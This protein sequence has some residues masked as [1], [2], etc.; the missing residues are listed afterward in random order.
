MN[1]SEWVV[2]ICMPDTVM[3]GHVRQIVQRYIDANLKVIATHT[4][5][6]DM[7][8]AARLYADQKGQDCYE[9]LLC[10]IT[11]GHCTLV[12]IREEDAVARVKEINGSRDQPGTICGDFPGAGGP[13]NTVHQPQ[14]REAARREIEIFFPGML[15][16]S[17]I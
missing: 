14:S 11:S 8:T 3:K 9:G 1:I 5:K 12:I 6:M 13:F 17:R 2:V 10:A 4:H 7:A 15:S 16:T